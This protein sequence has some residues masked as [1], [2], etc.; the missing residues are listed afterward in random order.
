[1]ELILTEDVP[2]LGKMGEIVKVKEGFGRN[3]LIPQKKA[4][5]SNSKNIKTLEAQKKIIAAKSA[6]L[7]Q[8]AEAMAAK[9]QSISLTIEKEVGANERLFGSVTNKEI[10]ELLAA[11]G[12]E[13]DRHKIILENPIKTIG[14]HQ[15][16]IKLH[17]D[18]KVPIKVSVTPKG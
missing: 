1:M 6:K 5:I 18:F 8:T 3:Y 12:V 9:L 15:V 11:Q 7:L 14:D 4:L 17:A 16:E 13:I 2:K 10:S